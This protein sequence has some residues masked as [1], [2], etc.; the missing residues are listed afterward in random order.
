MI[1][2]KDKKEKIEVGDE[3]IC[4]LGNDFEEDDLIEMYKQHLICIENVK[5]W[6][7]DTLIIPVESWH[8][9]KAITQLT[10]IE[11]QLGNPLIE[12]DIMRQEWKWK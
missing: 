8:A 10:F 12:E 3:L 7:G 11:V 2:N 4:A 1:L 9:L 5:S 6:A